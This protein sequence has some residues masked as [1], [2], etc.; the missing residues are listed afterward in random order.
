MLHNVVSYVVI[1]MMLITVVTKK[2][3]FN[4]QVFE[5]KV[6]SRNFGC[7]SVVQDDV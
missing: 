4:V 7:S 2:S 5:D 3:V 1:S 6:V